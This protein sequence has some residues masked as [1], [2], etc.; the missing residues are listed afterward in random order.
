MP[1]Y[2]D[3][4]DDDDTDDTAINYTPAYYAEVTKNIIRQE[5]LCGECEAAKLLVWAFNSES[6][7]AK[8]AWTTDFKVGREYAKDEKAYRYQ[9]RCDYFRTPVAHPKDLQHCGGFRKIAHKPKS[10]DAE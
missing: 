3:Y 2:D 4:D 9:V 7:A 8:I 5:I 1:T 10:G 6:V